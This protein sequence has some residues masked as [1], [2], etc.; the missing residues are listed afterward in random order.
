M[1]SGAIPK[2]EAEAQEAVEISSEMWKVNPIAYGDDFAQS[3]LLSAEFL[4]VTESDTTRVCALFE[5]AAHVAYEPRLKQL[6]TTKS[7]GC[8]SQ[9]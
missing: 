2:A 7:A 9:R 8:G 4:R 1:D 6:A 5:H 3:Q